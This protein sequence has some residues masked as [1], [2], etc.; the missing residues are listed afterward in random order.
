MSPGESLAGL[1]PLHCHSPLQQQ[2]SHVSK[3]TGEEE[4]AETTVDE[5]E[6]KENGEQK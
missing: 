1:L 3:G 6:E 5:N 2:L 4:T